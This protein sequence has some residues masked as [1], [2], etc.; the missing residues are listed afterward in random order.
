[1][2]SDRYLTAN[3]KDIRKWVIVANWLKAEFLLLFL[4]CFL[5]LLVPLSILFSLS[6][7]FLLFNSFILSFLKGHWLRNRFH[8]HKLFTRVLRNN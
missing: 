3:E 1:M 6:N 2:S 7:S 4:F 8:K 5:F